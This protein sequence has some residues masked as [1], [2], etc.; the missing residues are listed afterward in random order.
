MLVTSL[1]LTDFRNYRALDLGLEPGLTVVVGAN[2]QGKTNLLEAV[3]LASRFRS[4][5]TE[6]VRDVVRWGSDAAAIH[7]EAREASRARRIDALVGPRGLAVKVNGKAPRRRSDSIGTLS[8]VLFTPEDLRLVKGQPERRRAFI[9][10]VLGIARPPDAG[11]S[12]QYG[13]VMRQRNALLKQLREGLG[14]EQELRAWDENLVRAGVALTAARARVCGTLGPRAARVH[15]RI[16]GGEVLEV[17]YRSQLTGDPG[18]PASA[19]APDSGTDSGSRAPDTPGETPDGSGNHRSLEELAGEFRRRLAGRRREELIRGATLVG[20]HRDDVEL[21][22]DGHAARDFASQGQQRCA[23]LALKL[24][25]LES[26]T[27]ARGER[28]VLLLDDVMSE[29]DTTRRTALAEALA[30]LEQA[31]VTTTTPE[32]L[33]AVVHVPVRWLRVE[34]GRLA[35]GRV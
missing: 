10:D 25:E 31:I 14:S 13:K 8:A 34:D 11:L 27:E 3:M 17:R 26:I 32:Y 16:A 6:Q 4:P 35:E 29:L 22:I 24:A 2:G 18:D 5:R 28:P 9:D 19:V 20:P 33:E 7:A 23:V 21:R 30:E 12:A 15:R 1:K